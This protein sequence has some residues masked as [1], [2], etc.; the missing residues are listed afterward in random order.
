MNGTALHVADEQ[1]LGLNGSLTDTQ[2]RLGQYMT[3]AG[4]AELMA[5]MVRTRRWDR[6]CAVRVSGAT[7]APDVTVAVRACSVDTVPVEGIAYRTADGRVTVDRVEFGSLHWTGIDQTWNF[8]CAE[9]HSTELR[10]NYDAATDTYATTWAEIDVGCEA[11]HGPGSAH[12]AWAERQESWLPW[13]KGGDDGLTVHFDEREDVH[14]TIDPATGNATRSAPRTGATEL[15]TCGI[16][17]SRSARIAE[18]WRPG[19]QL[20]ETLATGPVRGRRQDAGRGLQLRLVS[21][22]QDVHTRRHL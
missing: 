18:G 22:E 16:C 6:G 15:E 17:H 12:V 13:G 5:S 21:S 11:C 14:W 8:M 9:C 2:S 4:I 3:P 19:Q 10:K 20:L 1:R 7:E